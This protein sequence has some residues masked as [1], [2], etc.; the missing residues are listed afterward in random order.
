VSYLPNDFHVFEDSQWKYD[1]YMITSLQ[2]GT[3]RRLHFSTLMSVAGCYGWKPAW[4]P[5]PPMIPG[6]ICYTDYFTYGD[7]IVETADAEAMA[8]ALEKARPYL[9]TVRETDEV[10]TVLNN[11]R[12][13][14]REDK[15]Y[16]EEHGADIDITSS[17]LEHPANHL[18][19]VDSLLFPNNAKEVDDFIRL[20]HKGAFR[21]GDLFNELLYF[22]LH[23]ILPPGR[24]KPLPWVSMPTMPLSDFKP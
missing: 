11:A 21:L 4:S 19:P 6:G 17:A 5:L 12:F 13:A 20:C 8:I 18:P 22:D 3:R 16:W 9:E 23:P 1:Q 10:M 2:D 7:T 15:A 24:L 14:F